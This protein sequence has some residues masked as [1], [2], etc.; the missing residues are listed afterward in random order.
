MSVGLL[1]PLIL[2]IVAIG[3]AVFAVLS[4]LEEKQVVRESL[5]SIDGYDL[6]AVPTDARA[7]QLQESITTRALIPAIARLTSTGRRFT[8]MGYA[9]KIRQKFVQAGIQTPD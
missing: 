9:D 8:P 3:G 7:E 6:D 4:R 5:R 2:V 1:L